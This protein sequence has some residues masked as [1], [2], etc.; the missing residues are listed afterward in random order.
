MKMYNIIYKLAN[1]YVEHYKKENRIYEAL[2]KEKIYIERVNDPY[3][4]AIE[5]IFNDVIGTDFSSALCDFA[6]H[7]SVDLKPSKVH[8][9]EEVDNLKRIV[10]I[11]MDNLTN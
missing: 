2:K 1:A 7:G 9:W 11:Y 8:P 10:D 5:S 3:T 4:S 6:E